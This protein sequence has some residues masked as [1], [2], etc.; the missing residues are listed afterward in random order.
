M[1]LVCQAENPTLHLPQEATKTAKKHKHTHL[2]FVRLIASLKRLNERHSEL[3][4]GENRN[5]TLQ[6]FLRDTLEKHSPST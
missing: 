4:Q 3:L 5:H 1:H 2:F 6:S